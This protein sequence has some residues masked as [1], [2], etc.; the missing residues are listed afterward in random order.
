MGN[1]SCSQPSFATSS[2]AANTATVSPAPNSFD[3]A[4]NPVLS[5][6]K[7]PTT[8]PFSA[9]I[10]A[11]RRCRPYSSGYLQQLR[12][13]AELF[14]GVARVGAGNLGVFAELQ[15][16]HDGECF[17]GAEDLREASEP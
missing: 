6:L 13:E 16:R 8:K 11:I 14:E 9:P 1:P 12:V 15:L 10:G 5:R 17:G 2:E 7:S 3:H 4:V